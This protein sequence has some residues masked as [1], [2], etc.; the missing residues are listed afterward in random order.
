MRLGAEGVR[1]TM[2][3]PPDDPERIIAAAIERHARGDKITGNML[4]G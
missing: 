3:Q 2:P 4:V 1:W